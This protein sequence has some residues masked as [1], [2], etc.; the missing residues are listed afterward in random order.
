MHYI[1]LVSNNEMAY[2]GD[3]ASSLPVRLLEY[4]LNLNDDNLTKRVRH[5]ATA[6]R[7]HTRYVM[8]MING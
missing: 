3:I 5:T 7:V 1:A 8:M 6:T 2:T 4:A